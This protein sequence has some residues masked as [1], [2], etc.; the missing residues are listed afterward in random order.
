MTNFN[1][2]W[3][4][5]YEGNPNKIKVDLPHDA[6]IEAKR[7][8]DAPSGAS[9][10]YFEG[11][12]YH[13]TKEFD[14]LVEWKEKNVYFEFEGVYRKAHIYINSMLACE[15]VYGYT[16]FSFCADEFLR[17][18]EKNVIEVIADNSE[19][20]NSRWYSGGGIYRPVWL[21]VKNKTHFELDGVT[22]ETV[23]INPP[24]VKLTAKKTGGDVS[25]S[26]MDE[27]KEIA[28]LQG[29]GKLVLEGA[30]LWSVET[31]NLYALKAT[32]IENGEIV[33][34]SEI[35]FGIREIKWSTKGF[36]VNGENVL[37][38]GGCVHHDNGILG[39][40]AYAEAEE[41]KA[42]IIKE[43]GFNAV[44]FSHNPCSKAFAAAC[45]KVGLY[46]IDELSDMWYM[47]KKKFDYALDFEKWYEKDITSMVAKDFNHP[48]VVM[49]SIGNEV[50][51]PYEQKGVDMAKKLVALIHSLDSC[52]PVT[53]GINLFIINNAAKGKGQYSEEKV[54]EDAIPKAQE[55]KPT[56]STLFNMI[57]SSAG[58]SMNKMA[59]SDEADRIT[60]PVLDCLDIAGYNYASGRY[61]M[62]G[63]K[64]PNRI[65]YGSETFP[66]DIYRN[67]Q[68]VKA[69]P[70]LLGDFMWTAWDYL[71][72]VGLGGWSYEPQYGMTF[73]KPYP[74]IIS[75]SGAIDLIGTI[76]AEAK[77][78]SIVWGLEKKPYIGVRPVNQDPKKLVKQVWRGTNAIESWSWKDCE[79]AKA[80][81]EVYSDAAFIEL[82][83]NEKK[84][85]RKKVKECKV[86]FKT[87]YRT[88]TL[89][90]VALD[91]T[92]KE[93]SRSELKSAT[94]K[95][96]IMLEIDKKVSEGEVAFIC[97]R[98]ADEGGITERN[99][100]QV[101]KAEVTGGKL[102]AF[103]SAQQK[104]EEKYSSNQTATY[105]GEALLVVQKEAA[106]LKVHVTGQNVAAGRLT[107]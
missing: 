9:G 65:I 48:S 75:D 12:I 85:G 3:T 43:A 89:T 53:A 80:E 5:F 54:E 17:Y 106:E 15:W 37:L 10:A 94:G 29:E 104:T 50:S 52:R 105:Y 11:G 23:S 70:Y 84:I 40:R 100:D 47:R 101:L 32:L 99:A 97:V 73:G 69:L 91:S 46:L 45:D 13:Y 63:A 68:K 64:H 78:A 86:L 62:E 49:Y 72:E 2:D 20:P 8:K 34:E 102:L 67:W 42:R 1:R 36:F 57:A 87:K 28:S 95:L 33:D 6:M 24:T 14:T 83:L 59:N 19:Q 21:H 90:A 61:E 71:G 35:T 74:W 7:S 56:S 60:T 16:G 82:Y 27:G 4:F 26:V 25:F 79:G 41:R 58:P 44:R 51:E 66:Q 30:K 31:P 98:I 77:Y 88:G 55:E 18:G 96:G 76:G 93:V 22:V 92:K 81:I 38:R 39:A 107:L 103:G